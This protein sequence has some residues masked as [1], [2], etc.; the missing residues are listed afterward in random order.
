MKWTM[1]SIAAFVLLIAAGS[2]YGGIYDG[3]GNAGCCGA[4]C[5]YG[6]SLWE[7]FCSGGDC[8]SACGKGGCGLGGF[9]KPASTGGGWWYGGAPGCGLARLRGPGCGA[10]GCGAGAGA[11]CG[12]CGES[13]CDGDCGC[14]G[15]GWGGGWWYGGSPCCGFARLRGHSCGTA[16]SYGWGMLGGW[17]TGC[18]DG[19]CAG[20][21]CGCQDA[22]CAGCG[23]GFSCQLR[24]MAEK[25]RSR[26]ACRSWMGGGL[27][28]CCGLTDGF[29]NSGFNYNY[30]NQWNAEPQPA[31]VMEAPMNTYGSGAVANPGYPNSANGSV[32]TA[33]ADSGDA[34]YESSQLGEEVPESPDFSN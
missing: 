27:L 22:G 33:P 14:Q 3:S 7:G 6:Y 34:V 31:P 11:C 32:E 5:N 10:P 2:S 1:A 15:P 26:M 9:C 30:I 24:G 18:C 19:G 16:S 28:D 8:G 4:D 13:T 20:G 21:S 17:D 12:A 23:G 29:C 25:F